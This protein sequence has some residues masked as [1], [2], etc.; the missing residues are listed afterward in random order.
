MLTKITLISFI[1]LNHSVNDY[2][3]MIKNSFVKSQLLI[4]NQN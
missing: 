4:T 2:L 1:N 3:I